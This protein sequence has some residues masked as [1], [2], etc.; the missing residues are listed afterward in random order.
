MGLVL[1]A[2]RI[3]R[4]TVAA[5]AVGERLDQYLAQAVE[6]L[7]RTQARKVIDL[8]GVHH[9]GRRVR[10]C[11]AQVRPGDVIEVYLD[12]FPLDPYRI[13]PQ[14][15]VYRDEYLLVLNKP[16]Q[17]DTQPTHARYKGTLY[18]A[19]QYHLKNPIRPHLQA[20][21]GMVQRLDRSTSGLIVFSIH[22][23]CHQPLTRLFHEQQ[24]EKNY[25]AL[26]E[27]C[28]DPPQGEIRSLLARSRDGNVVRSVPVGGKPAVTRYR[29]EQVMGVYAL[30][31]V[32]I[33][34]GRSHQIRAHMSEA[35]CPLV[36]DL[37]YGGG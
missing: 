3:H 11:S 10:A 4:L 19:L 26:V 8:G 22:P 17:I 35:G 16:A 36:G 32:R 15:I 29:V 33:L 6:D 12:H 13:A 5:E 27:G 20:N 18:E 7:S 31:A 14:D 9:N 2:W 23:R 24:I 25:L 34:T 37:R 30:V 21:I 1:K 28:P